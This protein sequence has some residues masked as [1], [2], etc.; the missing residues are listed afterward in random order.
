MPDRAAAIAAFVA[1][2]GWGDATARPLAGD[3]S[4]R[5]Y[6]RLSR[7]GQTAILMD[8]A[9]D[10]AGTARFAA[11]AGWLTGAGLSA[12]Q[13]LAD[14]AGDGLLLLEDLGDD[15]FARLLDRAPEAE[16]RLYS[17]TIDLL[18]VL[19][20]LPP[21]PDLPVWDAARLGELTEPFV[22]DFAPLAGV[23]AA[24]AAAVPG[25]VAD[26]ARA[27]LAP[28][29]VACLRDVHAENLIWLPA[30]PGVTAVGL[31][32]FQDAFLG[33]PAYDLASLLFDARRDLA[34]GLAERMTARFAAATGA[35]PAALATALALLSAQRNLRIL[36]VFARLA[37]AGGKPG[38]LRFVPRVLWH[39]RGALAHPALG[40][41]AGALG[42]LPDFA[43][44][45][46]A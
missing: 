11:L 9:G 33:D 22:T 46:D 21:P 10:A 1:A 8:A 24:R 37:G 29:R 17:A 16:E 39:L 12:P 25:L 34:P 30:R 32:D 4:A 13:V 35:D 7:V 42:P 19:H 3:A 38:Y 40:P 23:G 2:A 18:A 44:P 43:V 41:L 14:A 20:R 15:L 36:G 28:P 31:L 45:A 6:L 26:L 27:L 5:R